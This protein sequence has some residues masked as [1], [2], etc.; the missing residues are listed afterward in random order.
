MAIEQQY[1]TKSHANAMQNLYMNEKTAD[2]HFIFEVES[3]EERVPVH[4]I[5]LASASPVFHA[6]FYGNLKEKNDVKITDASADGF[7]AFLALFYFCKVTISD[8]NYDE[9]LYL[10]HKYD[11]P[12]GLNICEKFLLAN[13]SV[14]DLCKHL[15]L[16]I[17]FNLNELEKYCETEIR[18]NTAVVFKTIGFIESPKDVLESILKLRDHNCLDMNV[19]N[20]CIA[21]A[22]NSCKTKG[23]DAKDTQ[24]IR[25]ELGDLFYHIPFAAMKI[26]TFSKVVFAH[27]TLFTLDEVADIM[28]LITSGE[29]TDVSEKFTQNRRVVNTFDWDE[30]VLIKIVRGSMGEIGTSISPFEGIAFTSNTK[31][32]FGGFDLFDVKNTSDSSQTL[33][34]TISITKRNSD[35]IDSEKI[36]QNIQCI[37]CAEGDRA[38]PFSIK[39]DEPIVIVPQLR[40]DIEVDF[41]SNQMSE[42]DGVVDKWEYLAGERSFDDVFAKD[43][44]NIHF[45]EFH[46]FQNVI[47]DYS[48][49]QKVYFNSLS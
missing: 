45:Y 33:S 9:F 41:S 34:A 30:D 1:S 21:W 25:R 16:A 42:E 44:I 20:A 43:Y 15:G 37:V 49:V 13:T 12:E 47:E 40:Y 29:L 23:T 4:K 27:R 48:I 14:V 18:L 36:Q 8:E 38:V 22:G 6:M 28:A 24:N 19:F 3:K 5:I 35:G 39:L 10:S 26:D 32:L 46:C 31:L 17:K 11:M 2:V 7:K